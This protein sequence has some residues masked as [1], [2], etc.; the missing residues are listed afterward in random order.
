MGHGFLWVFRRAVR[1]ECDLEHISYP[2][3]KIRQ[4]TKKKLFQIPR[5]GR[6]FSFA[7]SW[8]LSASESVMLSATSLYC[9][10]YK[11]PMVC[12]EI[13]SVGCCGIIKRKSVWFLCLVPGTEL[14]KPWN[15]L[16]V[17]YA[18]EMTPNGGW[19]PLGTREGAVY[20]K[21]QS[22][23][24]GRNFQPLPWTSGKERLEIEFNHQ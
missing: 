24:A 10:F 16:C 19:E 21:E 18:N 17:L 7:P 4:F 8:L 14:P 6:I 3:F 1:R 20:Q 23:W 9:R 22:C 2:L 12:N 15:Y 11:G 13:N 5:T